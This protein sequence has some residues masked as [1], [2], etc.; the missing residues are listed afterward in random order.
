MEFDCDAIERGY[1]MFNLANLG[2]GCKAFETDEHVI[3][4]EE[5][6]QISC[7]ENL[8]MESFS[9]DA[10]SEPL[11]CKS[12]TQVTK[13]L[14]TIRQEFCKSKLETSEPP[15]EFSDSGCEVMRPRAG[16]LFSTDN[17]PSPY[18]GNQNC[19]FKLSASHGKRVHLTFLLIDVGEGYLS[20][21]GGRT[22]RCYGD[23]IAVFDSNGTQIHK[24]CGTNLANVEV[25]FFFRI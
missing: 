15:L 5:C 8:I 12:L 10:D 11:D 21:R 24:F 19:S 6:R 9:C 13:N 14:F 7:L 25:K 3:P 22:D 1:N 18:S 23:S 16:Q 2:L 4:L 20:F 17:F